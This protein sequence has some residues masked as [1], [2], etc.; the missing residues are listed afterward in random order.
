MESYEINT[1]HS[2]FCEPKNILKVMS[3]VL[4]ASDSI[5]VTFLLQPQIF[6]GKKDFKS[7]F[8]SRNQKGKELLSSS[9]LILKLP[10]HKFFWPKS[11][12][13]DII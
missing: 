8:W 9:Y 1:D 6:T 13:A 2:P 5:E 4:G 11:I 10:P 7:L 3:V 12:G